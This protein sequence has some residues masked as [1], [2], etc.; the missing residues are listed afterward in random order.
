MLSQFDIP[1]LKTFLIIISC[2]E[3]LVLHS[4]VEQYFCECFLAFNN[5]RIIC[6][7]VA[8]C[9]LAP[10]LERDAETEVFYVVRNLLYSIYF[11]R[12]HAPSRKLTCACLNAFAQAFELYFS[13]ASSVSTCLNGTLSGVDTQVRM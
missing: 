11:T 8:T 6:S 2:L 3:L 12:V 4:I 1:K 7:A 5:F 9:I 10:L 13:C